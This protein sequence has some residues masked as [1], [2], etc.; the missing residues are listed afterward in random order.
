LLLQGEKILLAL[1]KGILE[2]YLG[3]FEKELASLLDYDSM[4]PD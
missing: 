2:K 1:F 3:D 4:P